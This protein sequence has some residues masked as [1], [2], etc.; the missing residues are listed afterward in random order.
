MRRIGGVAFL[1][2]V[3]RPVDLVVPRAP[4]PVV[5]P[6]E[7][8]DARAGDIERDVEIIAELIQVMRGVR[9]LVASAA[10][11][12]AAHVGPG[13][14]PL[15]R[16]SLPLEVGIRSDRDDGRLRGRQQAGRKEAGS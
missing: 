1:H 14:D 3:F 15:V 4:V 16:P 8:E 11:V 10:V 7:I 13:A 6:D 5:V 12:G 2:Q 9:R